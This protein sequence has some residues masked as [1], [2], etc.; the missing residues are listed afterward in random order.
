VENWDDEVLK[1][2]N[3]RGVD[4]VVEVGGAGTLPKSVN[5]VRY[6]GYVHV[7]GFVA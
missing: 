3:G 5:V 6:A 7:I 2:T 4:H 1:L